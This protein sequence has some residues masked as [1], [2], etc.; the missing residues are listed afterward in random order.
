MVS[1][2]R[3]ETYLRE[4]GETPYA[5]SKRCPVPRQTIES[6][7][8]GRGTTVDTAIHIVE[9]TRGVV[10]YKDLCRKKGN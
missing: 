1:P 3:L 9:A 10:D 7:C 2:M 5:L 6:I 4:Q 8:L